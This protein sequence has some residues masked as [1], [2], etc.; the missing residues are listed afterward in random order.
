MTTA[1]S[2]SSSSTP[3]GAGPR[4]VDRARRCPRA[5]TSVSARHT[6]YFE[7]LDVAARRLRLLLRPCPR[8]HARQAIQ[9]GAQ[10]HLLPRSPAVRAGIRADREPVD[11]RIGLQ[12]RDRRAGQ[13]A[14]SG[15]RRHLEAGSSSAGCRRRAVRAGYPGGRADGGRSQGARRAD[16]ELV[17]RVDDE[18]SAGTVA[19]DRSRQ[20]RPDQAG[21]RRDGGCRQ[22]DGAGG[23]LARGARDRRRRCRRRC[24]R[25]TRS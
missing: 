23:R 14:A 20:P 11:V 5:P 9:R 2:G 19:W 22:R 17:P 24:G 18:R 16:S 7:D 6:L 15:H 1:S 21:R 25:S 12:R 4:P 3:C 8:R 10:R 13:R